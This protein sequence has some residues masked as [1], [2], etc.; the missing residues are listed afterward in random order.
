MADNAAT[1]DILAS[2]DLI[3]PCWELLKETHHLAPRIN[4][5][6]GKRAGFLD[7]RK[8]NADVVLKRLASRLE[9]DYGTVTSL[10]RTKAVY[11]RRAE[12]PMLDEFAHNCDFVITA[13]GA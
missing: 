8:D 2:M 4:A 7:N 9:A 3:N 1:N 10:Y 6:S 5:L 12:S 11:S 13:T